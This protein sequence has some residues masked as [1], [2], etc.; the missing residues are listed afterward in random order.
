MIYIEN[1]AVV[2]WQNLWEYECGVHLFIYLYSSSLLVNGNHFNL[3][4][5]GWFTAGPWMKPWCAL[6]LNEFK[7]K[8]STVDHLFW[9]KKR[10]ILK[11]CV[12]LCEHE[13]FVL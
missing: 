7:I 5:Y 1:L 4:T 10:P 8:I 12:R 2:I 11:M 13:K 3:L 6:L 9:Q